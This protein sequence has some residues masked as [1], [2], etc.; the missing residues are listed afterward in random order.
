M[1]YHNAYDGYRRPESASGDV[2][3]VQA[4]VVQAERQADLAHGASAAR[5][6]IHTVFVAHHRLQ[7]EVL[8]SFIKQSDCLDLF[9]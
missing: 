8:W 6:G 1:T 4:V 9:I 2:H 3:V 7:D 5:L